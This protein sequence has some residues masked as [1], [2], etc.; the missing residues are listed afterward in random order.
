MN[1]KKLSKALIE[2]WERKIGKDREDSAKFWEEF[3]S[4]KRIFTAKNYEH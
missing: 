3:Y 2:M 4:K 1:Y